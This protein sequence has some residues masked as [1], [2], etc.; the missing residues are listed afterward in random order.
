MITTVQYLPRRGQPILARS[1]CGVD[2]ILVNSYLP[3]IGQNLNLI[4]DE[5]WSPYEYCLICKN[6]MLP[7]AIVTCLLQAWVRVTL[8]L[9]IFYAY[10]QSFQHHPKCLAFGSRLMS[11]Y[12]RTSILRFQNICSASAPLCCGTFLAGIQVQ[13]LSGIY[14]FLL[15][16]R[17][18][19]VYVRSRL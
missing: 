16:R 14:I 3:D 9:C 4:N 10:L 6:N 18:S 1:A 17:L 19:A 13:Y 11:L 2:N 7:C 8:L 15:N 5:L 12:G